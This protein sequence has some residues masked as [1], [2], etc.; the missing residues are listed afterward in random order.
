MWINLHTK[1]AILNNEEKSVY[2]A[3]IEMIKSYKGAFYVY[4]Q[5]NLGEI[6]SSSTDDGH[7]AINSKR[8]D[9]CISNKHFEPIAVVEYQGSGHF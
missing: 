1:K 8:V 2:F 9:F 6:I 4:S 7:S 5:V 3:L